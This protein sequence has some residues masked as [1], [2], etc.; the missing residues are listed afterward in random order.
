MARGRPLPR[1][2]PEDIEHLDGAA[3]GELRIPRCVDCG[4]EFWPAG[5]V[6]PYDF[7][8]HLEWT[9]DPGTGVINSWVRCH[10][11]YFPGDD[12]PYYVVQVTLDAGPNITTS[13]TG[14][15]APEIGMPAVASFRQVNDQIYLPEFGPSHL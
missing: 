8:E 1:R 3:R 12:V 15:T 7:S 14:A 6:C 9:T 5:P 13:W 11:Q 4:R 10:R 2:Y